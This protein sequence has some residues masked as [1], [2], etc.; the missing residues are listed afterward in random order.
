MSGRN[1]DAAA[2][3]GDLT[4]LTAAIDAGWR[5]CRSPGLVAISPSG[6]TLLALRTPVGVSLTTQAGQRLATHVQ[7]GTPGVQRL[8]GAAFVNDDLV[9]LSLTERTRE[10][11]VSAFVSCS[12][13]TA[14]CQRVTDPVPAGQAPGA[15]FLVAPPCN[16]EGGG[17]GGAG[18]EL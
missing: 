9:V 14:A 7:D 4:A 8:E 16:H 11:A 15:A 5:H 17:R 10:G 12:V 3:A 1:F 13:T 2:C 6:R 18:G